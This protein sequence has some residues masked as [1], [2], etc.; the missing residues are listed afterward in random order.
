MKYNNKGFSLIDIAV[1]MSIITTTTLIL[2][3]QFLKV[4]DDACLA[5]DKQN[6]NSLIKAFQLALIEAENTDIDSDFIT[7]EWITDE[8][9][10]HK[11]FLKV[12]DIN[13]SQELLSV[14]LEILSIE[15]KENDE[16]IAF[17]KGKSNLSKEHNFVFQINTKTG[18]T[19]IFEE[20]D[21]WLDEIDIDL[22][23]F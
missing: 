1:T 13:N 14:A 18:E 3:P 5:I 4:F 16:Y 9:N 21:K 15:Y 20:S 17:I 7:V 10:M 23:E 2:L 6:A 8:N 19:I 22:D 12:S 11:G